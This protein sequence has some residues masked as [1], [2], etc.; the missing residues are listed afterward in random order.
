MLHNCLHNNFPLVCNHSYKAIKKE[1]NC[2]IKLQAGML[3]TCLF[4]FLKD[5]Y[6]QIEACLTWFHSVVVIT[7]P[8]HGEGP[9]FTPGW[10]HLESF[11]CS[12]SLC[13]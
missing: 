1:G 3:R 2:K 11:N 12:Q 10:R 8:L 4:T 5:R 13:N 7:S 9:Q 6:L